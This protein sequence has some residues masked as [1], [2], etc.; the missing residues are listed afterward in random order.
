M[1]VHKI[2]MLLPLS[3]VIL[4]FCDFAY[5][6]NLNN[7]YSISVYFL[8]FMIFDHQRVSFCIFT[9]TMKPNHFRKH[10]VKQSKLQ[11]PVR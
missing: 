6:L 9:A 3:T 7:T 5:N 4:H 10:Y 8:K 1:P 11:R 2:A